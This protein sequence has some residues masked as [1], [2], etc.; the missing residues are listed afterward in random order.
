MHNLSATLIMRLREI[1]VTAMAHKFE[2]IPSLV[3]K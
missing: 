3:L 2:L 1:T